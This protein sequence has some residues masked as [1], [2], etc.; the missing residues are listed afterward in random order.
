MIKL[1]DLAAGS[2]GAAAAGGD[3]R[4][5]ALCCRLRGKP[6]RPEAPASHHRYRILRWRARAVAAVTFTADWAWTGAWQTALAVS[7]ALARSSG[8][9]RASLGG[10]AGPAARRAHSNVR[11]KECC[12]SSSRTSSEIWAVTTIWRAAVQ[13]WNSMLKGNQY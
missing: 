13:W 2:G 7:D 12:V 3:W 8:W 4:L 10:S 6:G 1:A 9:L 11:E 5:R